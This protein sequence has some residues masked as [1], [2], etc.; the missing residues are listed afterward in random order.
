MSTKKLTPAQLQTLEFFKEEIFNE[1]KPEE[2]HNILDGLFT[3]VYLSDDFE[4]SERFR[5]LLAFKAF[6]RFTTLL[7]TGEITNDILEIKV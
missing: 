4:A 6:K 5:F 3:Y 2:M 7:K 1:Q